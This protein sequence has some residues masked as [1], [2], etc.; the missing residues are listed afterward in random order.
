MLEHGYKLAAVNRDLSALGSAY[1]W[2]K[3]KRF[4]ARAGQPNELPAPSAKPTS[5]KR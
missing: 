5:T 4:S 1:R 2:A 3:A